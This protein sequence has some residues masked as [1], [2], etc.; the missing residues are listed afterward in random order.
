[1]SSAVGAKTTDTVQLEDPASTEPQVWLE[2]AKS[3][4][5][6]PEMAMLVIEIFE[7]LMFLSFTV[8]GSL[9]ERR[10]TL[11][12]E[13]LWGVTSTPD[14]RQP[15]CCKARRDR[16]ALTMVAP[17]RF[18]PRGGNEGRLSTAVLAR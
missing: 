12:K 4:A 17:A 11:P 15:V 5:L 2:M 1:M 16:N 7:V 3:V 18:L 9:V 10:E 6:E 14:T 8:C 13:R